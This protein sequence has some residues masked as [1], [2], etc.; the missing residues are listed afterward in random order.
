MELLCPDT[1]F[2]SIYLVCPTK[3]LV[4]CYCCHFASE[5]MEVMVGAGPQTSYSR[6][7]SRIKTR[8]SCSQTLVLKHKVEPAIF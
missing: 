8:I 5:R 1:Y 6:D 3:E 2:L 7:R 4:R